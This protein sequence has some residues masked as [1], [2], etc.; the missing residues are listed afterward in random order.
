MSKIVPRMVIRLSAVT[1]AAVGCLLLSC[2]QLEFQG[3]GYDYRAETYLQSLPDDSTRTYWLKLYG[4]I[5][6][7]SPTLRKHLQYLDIQ[8]DRT[9]IDSLVEDFKMRRDFETRPDTPD[10]NEWWD[11]VWNVRAAHCDSFYRSLSPERRWDLRAQPVIV[12][13]LPDAERIELCTACPARYR[14]S[15]CPSCSTSTCQ[16]YYMDWMAQNFFLKY[17]DYGCRGEF[18]ETIK[19]D[20]SIVR[21]SSRMSSELIGHQPRFNPH[22]EVKKEIKAAVEVFSFPDGD[23]YALWIGSGVGLN[24]YVADSTERV[25]F[26]QRVIIHRAEAK[27]RLVLSDSTPPMTLPLPDSADNLDDY[28]FPLNFGGYRLPAGMYDIYLMLFDDRDSTHLGTYRTLATLPSTH[29]STGISEIL[30]ALQTAGRAFEGTANRVVRGDYTLL[31]NP[32]YYHRGDT[33][34]PYIEIDLSD[35]KSSQ[36]G[37]YDYTVLASIYRAREGPGRPT[38][39]VGDIFNVDYDTL[40]SAPSQ[41]QL[42]R[43]QPKSEALI[44][45]TSRR[46]TKPK[47][48]FQEPMVLPKTLP[49]GKYF[50]VMSAQDASSRKYLTSW[51]EIKVKK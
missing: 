49:A 16:Y 26:H 15:R 9:T 19:S 43:N 20:E 22:P 36:E 11:E 48:A 14:N 46:S 37:V 4:I 35:F 39:D 32:A 8:E 51:R 5:E 42:R 25:S 50:L 21:N 24:Q 28:W 23:E 34:Y 44:Y 12:F 3:L 29:A 1:T 30:V 45:S 41:Q 31:A 17:L 47:V 13:G 33:I 27:P 18:D 40:G 2:T 10:R 6:I 7:V 38:T